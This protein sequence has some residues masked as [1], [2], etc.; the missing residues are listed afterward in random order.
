MRPLSIL[1]AIVLGVLALPWPACGTGTEPS[2]DDTLTLW[3]TKPSAQWTDALPIGNGRLGAM[4]YGGVER[5]RIRLN[6]DTLW[7]GYRRNADNPASLQALPQVRDLLFTGKNNEA[8]KLASRTMI[9]NPRGVRSYQALGDLSIEMIDAPRSAEGYR[10]D[11]NLDT[12]IASVRFQADGVRYTREVFSSRPDN[13]IV[14]RL[15]ADKP[16]G[17]NVRVGMSRQKDATI[18]TEEG[19][20]NGLI[21]RGR[22]NRP[23]DKTGEQRGMK[24]EGQLLA[25]PQG[26]TVTA[27]D[28]LL[29]VAKTDS[30]V[31]LLAAATDFHGGDPAKI[32]RATLTAAAKKPY[33]ALRAAHVAE[34]QRLFRRVELKLAP[35]AHDFELPKSA[36]LR[37]FDAPPTADDVRRLPTNE[38]LDRVKKGGEDSGLVVQYFQFGRYL[39]ASCS[40]PGGQPANLQGLWSEGLS[41][42][43]GADYHTNINIQMNYWPTEVCNLSECHLPLFDFMDTLVEPGSRTAK[44]MY[45]CRGWVVHHLSD[46]FDR[47]APADGIQGVWPMGSAWLAQHP[48]EHYLFTNDKAFLARQGYPLMKG[49]ARFILDFLMEAPAGTPVAG[50]LVTN[51]S[52]SPENTFIKADGSRAMFTYAATMDLEIVNDL[53]TN[54]IAASKVLSTDEAFRAECARALARLAPLQISKKTGRLQEWVEDYG[55]AEPQHRH[56]SHLFG[57]HPGHSISITETPELAAAARKS[58]V[59]RG[60]GGTGWSM[61]W[62]V[63]FWA[64]LR[65]GDHAYKMLSNLLK[66]GTLPDLFDTHPPFQI[67]GN[68]GGTAGI[69]EMLIQSHA[70]EIHLLPALPKAWPAGQYKGLCARGAF[71]ADVTWKGGAIETATIR[72]K[73]G[74]TVRIRTAAPMDVTV[75]G[76]AVRVTRPERTVVEFPTETGRAYELAP[77]KAADTK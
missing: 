25:I 36:R 39:L 58:L 12:A 14:I 46:I 50:K 13:C 69:A 57:L 41:A 45:G 47:T 64:R 53:L 56:V 49:A 29:T 5:E 18:L 70:G 75:V 43:W 26:G 68:F 10:R 40:R 42:P 32:C 6:E 19:F 16:G 7:D 17:I 44:E 33:D 2:V 67:D 51:P 22:I 3:Y 11:L 15:S 52:Y 20:A 27:K 28:G 76:Q 38:R 72:S 73:A 9:G 74:N 54:C 23:D 62:K 30:V 71:E 59:G 24:F 37:K 55:D 77:A 8:T 60:D 65:D 4:I 31:L 1:T 66:N 35:T 21:L 34:H 48:Y 61:A 63:N